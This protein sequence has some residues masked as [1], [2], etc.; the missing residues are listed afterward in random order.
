MKIVKIA[1]AALLVLGAA[2][3]A[4]V[5]RPESAGG[6]AQDAREGITVTGSGEVRSRP[7]RATLT[8]G[9]QA[10]GGTSA[11]ALAANSA[12]IRSLIGALKQAGVDA[13][14]LKS[15]YLDVSPRYERDGYTASA[16]VTVSNQPLERASRLADIAVEHGADTVSGPSL[17]VADSKA[18]Y[19]RALER[20]FDDARAKAQTLAA[21][22]GVSLGE[23]TAIVEGSRPEFPVY[24][25][26]ERALD[27]K[28]PIEPGSEE[29]TAVVTVTFAL[30]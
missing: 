17:S 10:R 26:A 12:E 29:I 22:A 21:A 16:S 28:T 11:A 15:D 5:G 23:V 18:E 24:A 8:F 25:T 14:D 13:K 3:L 2:A 19:R 1:V 6:A 30:A 7:D 20:A 4:G 27:A 9:V